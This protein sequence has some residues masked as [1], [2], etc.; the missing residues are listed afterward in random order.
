MEIKR[1]IKFTV[2]KGTK[3]PKTINDSTLMFGLYMQETFKIRR[4]ETEKVTMNFIVYLPKEIFA[5]I[6]VLPFLQKET[7][8]L[9]DCQSTSDQGKKS[10]TRII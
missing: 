1:N 3:K 8:V 9:K 4:G 6:V 5:I 10:R 7:L 2:K